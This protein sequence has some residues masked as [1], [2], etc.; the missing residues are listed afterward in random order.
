MK[1]I[2][3]KKFKKNINITVIY[4]CFLQIKTV[5]EYYQK[6]KE[7]LQKE[8]RERYQNRSEERKLAPVSS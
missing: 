4:N 2:L 5:N 3:M 8:A 7:K 1:K 6:Q